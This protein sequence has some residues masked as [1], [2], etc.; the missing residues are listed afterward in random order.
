VS[1]VESLIGLS[2]YCE[3]IIPNHA[4]IVAPLRELCRKNVKWAWEDK[5]TEAVNQLK[6]ACSTKALSFFNKN[7]ETELHVDASTDGLGAVLMQQDIECNHHVIAYASKSLNDVQK[8]YSQVEKEGLRAVWACEKFHLYVYGKYFRLIVDNKAIEHIFNNPK[9]KIPA[10]IERWCLR[11]AQYNFLVVHR[12]VKGNPADYLSRN[13]VLSE[14]DAHDMAEHYINYLMSE[15]IPPAISQELLEIETSKDECL[16]AVIRRI[17]GAIKN[18]NDFDHVFDELSV[19]GQ[20][21]KALIMRSN[22]VLIPLILQRCVVLIALDGHQGV[23]KTKELLRSKVWFVG[24]N[25]LVEEVIR[26]CHSCQINT[27]SVSSEPVRMSEMPNGPREQLDG[28]IY[29][30]TVDGTLLLV[31]IDIFEVSNCAAI[32]SSSAIKVIPVLHEIISTFGVND[33]LKT[34][35]SPP[36]NGA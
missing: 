9:A 30:P 6:K 5:H 7:L 19:V 10:R 25:K 1:Q 8:R 13:P 27:K 17:S 34:D 22:R 28:D 18:E 31:L 23:S 26:S 24:I 20:D 21:E 11:L 33:N 3:K 32:A 4:A 2:Q 29:G 35:N 12:P 15:A 36:F 14:Q 16:Q